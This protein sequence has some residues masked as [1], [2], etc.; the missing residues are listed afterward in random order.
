MLVSSPHTDVQCRHL[1]MESSHYT[2]L[3]EGES[4]FHVYRARNITPYGAGEIQ[5]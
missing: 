1:D 3:G 5:L 2:A 4:Q